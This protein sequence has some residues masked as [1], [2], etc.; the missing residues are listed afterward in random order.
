MRSERLRHMHMTKTLAKWFGW[1]L[2]IVGIL[3]FF[4][5]PLIGN[6]GYFHANGAHDIVH[7]LLGVIFL[8]AAKT[9]ASAAL[10]LKIIGIVTIIVAILG[11][12]SSSDM[13]LGFIATNAAA[14]WLHA[15]LGIVFFLCGFSGGKKMATG[16]QM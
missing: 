5:N 12:M 2:I 14:N 8:L 16:A 1:I 11:F 9:E 13:I 6:V 3:G 4:S 15:V 10:W 7:L